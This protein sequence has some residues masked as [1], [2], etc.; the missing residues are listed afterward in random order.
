MYAEGAGLSTFREVRP[1]W[2]TAPIFFYLLDKIG[3]KTINE[4]YYSQIKVLNTIKYE[5][6]KIPPLNGEINES[7]EATPFIIVYRLQ[8]NDETIRP[9][10]YSLSLS[11]LSLQ[12][13][14]Q[15]V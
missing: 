12:S 2:N 4:T 13:L 3:F 5:R 1:L 15:I 7:I 8:K 6:Y 11:K 10:F 14:V 9:V